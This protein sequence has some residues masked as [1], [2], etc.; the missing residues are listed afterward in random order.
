MTTR[1]AAAT[2][3]PPGRQQAPLSSITLPSAD[4]IDLQAAS[5][6]DI[7]ALDELDLFA[8]L[9]Q[10][11]T[12]VDLSAQARLYADRDALYT[13]RLEDITLSDVGMA[14]S[15]IEKFELEMGHLEEQIE[16]T[17]EDIRDIEAIDGKS[18]T[19]CK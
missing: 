6:L 15:E 16:M 12:Q 10:D 18:L 8:E 2:T 3:L 17:H 5:Q 9:S 13:A 11:L 1:D 14:E 7:S 19:R 4:A